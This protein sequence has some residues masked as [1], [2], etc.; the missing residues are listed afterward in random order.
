EHKS[1]AMDNVGGEPG[2][3]G[4]NSCAPRP[5]RSWHATDLLLLCPAHVGSCSG[6]HTSRY[7]KAGS[8]CFTMRGKDSGFWLKLKSVERSSAFLSLMPSAGRAKSH[9]MNARILPVEDVTL[10]S[11]DFG[12]AYGETST[13]GTLG[14]ICRPSGA[15]GGL[16]WS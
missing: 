6:N 10:E 15:S 4:R 12:L 13:K 8:F 3:P 7:A 5:R 16:T 9:S 14:P 2:Q 1:D 11:V